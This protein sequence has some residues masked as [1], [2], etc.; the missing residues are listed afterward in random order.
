MAA[1][2]E[3]MSFW[4]KIGSFTDS[5]YKIYISAQLNTKKIFKYAM[6]LVFIYHSFKYLFGI[7]VCSM[8]TCLLNFQILAQNDTFSI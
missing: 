1:K 2:I 3:E 8:L 5:V 6:Y 7:C 4:T